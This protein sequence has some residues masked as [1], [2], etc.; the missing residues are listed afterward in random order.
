MA[1]VAAG[2]AVYGLAELVVSG[3]R[4]AGTLKT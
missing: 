3:G 4:D 2:L 1:A